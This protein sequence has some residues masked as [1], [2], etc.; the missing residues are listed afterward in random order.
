MKEKKMK[1][2][3]AAIITGVTLTLSGGASYAEMD[4]PM[5]D[6][7]KHENMK[8]EMEMKMPEGLSMKT[9]QV[10]D[11]NLTFHV[12]TMPEYHKL[13]KAMGMKHSQME[14]DTSHHI[15]VDVTDKDGKK[16]TKAAVKVK[17]INPRKES[18]EKPLKPMMGQL[19]QYGADFK[20]IHEGKHQV[21][22]LFKVG[23]KMHKGGYWYE[24]K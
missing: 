11:Y 7:M 1:K 2:K 8:H 20:M 10:D 17:V 3:I 6:K 15:M 24:Q 5:G 18:Q 21:M 23:G 22:I 14:G 4:H 12:M 19:G 16:V 9:L 13:M